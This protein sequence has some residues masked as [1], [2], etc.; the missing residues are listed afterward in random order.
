M[1]TDRL[2]IRGLAIL[3]VLCAALSVVTESYGDPP[4]RVR[5]QLTDEPGSW[6]TSEAGP[7]A[8]TRS[9]AVAAPGT[10]VKFMGRSHT[11]HTMS[12]LIYPTGAVGMPFDTDATQG[13]RKVDL[14]TPG[15]YVFVCKIHPYMLGAVIVDDPSTTG[16]DLGESLSLIHGPVIPSSSDLATRLLRAFFIITN[17]GN[18]QDFSSSAPWHVTYPDVPVRITGGLVVNLRAVLN[19]RYGNDTALPSLFTP[20]VPGVGEVWVNTQYEKTAGKSKP[21][22]ATRVDAKTWQ[23]TR[24]VALPQINMNNPHNMWTDRNQELIYAAQWFDQRLTVFDRATGRLVRNLV[25]GQAPAH[26]MT[27][28]DTDQVHVTVNGAKHEKAVVELSAGA[29]HIERRLDIGRPH[30]HAHWM[31]HDGKTMV[32]PNM[33][34][35]DASTYDFPSDTHEVVPAGAMPIA[36]GMMPDSSKHY[37]ANYLGGSIS[38]IATATHQLLRTI[39]LLAN[40]N[41]I[42]GEI[43]GPVGGLPIQTPVSPNGRY[44]V[45]ANTLTASIIVTDTLTDTI[46]KMLPCDAGCHGVQ[47]G[48]K[49]GGGYYAYVS[50]KFANTLLVVDPDPNGDGIA[51]DAALV[52]RLLLTATS[53]T[54]RDDQITGLA[55]MGGQGVLPIPVVYNGWVQNLPEAWSRQLTERQRQPFP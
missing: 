50:S 19:A 23:V 11:V 20:A 46:V 12:T 40:Y 22:T 10:E 52:G 49:L 33:F 21:G 6:F 44:M 53:S 17:P 31:S 7:I 54:A 29:C 1:R 2:P 14:V 30:P 37:V 32:T 51:L 43:T 39:D 18:W 47:F 26:V 48:A 15:L 24:K 41:P 42:T 35:D 25:V 38:V 9:L 28:V 16:L 34:T 27:R 45:T 36:T 13:S 8:G 5:F 55:G 3:A 4:R